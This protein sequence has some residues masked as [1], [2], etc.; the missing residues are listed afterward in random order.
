MRVL[1][2]NEF[3]TWINDVSCAF[4]HPFKTSV[5][6]FRKRWDGAV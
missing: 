6:F 5:Q 3:L 1:Y 4:G 2:K